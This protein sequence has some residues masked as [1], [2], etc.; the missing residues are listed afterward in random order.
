[1]ITEETLNLLPTLDCDQLIGNQNLLLQKIN[2]Q[3]KILHDTIEHMQ[4]LTQ[5]VAMLSVEISEGI[6]TITEK[7]EQPMAV[8]VLKDANPEENEAFRLEQIDDKQQLDSLENTLIDKAE[9][10][11][12]QKQLSF[13]FQPCEGNGL[14]FAYKL[15]DSLITRD[16]MCK[17]S[18]SGASRGNCSKIP[19]KDF[20]NFIKFFCD[21][22]RVRS[23]DPTFTMGQTE[24]FFKI[25]LKNAVKRRAMKDLRFSTKR[26]QKTKPK[27]TI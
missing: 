13:L 17:C 12:L 19:L 25:S 7:I 15:L 10:A 24:K 26:I 22:I 6:A 2:N 18:W 16:F 9:R 1:M 21:M 23:W 3:D 11:K 4:K 8:T 5:K 27:S 20:K 14:T